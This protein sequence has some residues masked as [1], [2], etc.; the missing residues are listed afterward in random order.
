MRPSLATRV[1]HAARDQRQA[2]QRDPLNVKNATRENIRQDQ[3]ISA[4][5]AKQV[6]SLT[7]ERFRATYV[8]S[9]NIA[10]LWEVRVAQI[11]AGTLTLLGV[12]TVALNVSKVI[13]TH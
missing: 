5:Y 4:H 2:R 7:Q 10:N 3:L 1:K 6:R 9:A 12:Q 13:T 11:A 8:K